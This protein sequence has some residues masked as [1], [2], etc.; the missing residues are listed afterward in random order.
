MRTQSAQVCQTHGANSTK[1]PYLLAN[2]RVA[3]VVG[4]W[5]ADAELCDS[6]GMG[7]GIFKN[8]HRSVGLHLS[9]HSRQVYDRQ[10]HDRDLMREAVLQS[11][12][13]RFAKFPR[14]QIYI[15]Y[16]F[17]AVTTIQTNLSDVSVLRGVEL[18]RKY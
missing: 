6:N 11:K 7:F 15:G 8:I 13:E 14:Q 1:T 3:F 4:G 9:V 17:A 16:P 18:Q 5:V 12:A 2:S 10:G